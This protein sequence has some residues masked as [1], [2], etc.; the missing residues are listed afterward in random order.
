MSCVPKEDTNVME[1]RMLRKDLVEEAIQNLP[2]FFEVEQKYQI[3]LWQ[4]KEFKEK[5][6]K[7]DKETPN[8]R[9]ELLQRDFSARADFLERVYLASVDDDYID[10]DA[11]GRYGDFICSHN[12]TSFEDTLEGKPIHPRIKQLL[13]PL[14]TPELKDRTISGAVELQQSSDQKEM[15][16]EHLYPYSNLQE[17]L[18]SYEEV[19]SLMKKAAEK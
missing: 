17:M 7:L 11:F 6:K 16:D 12:Q 3:P 5:I 4:K 15:I 18:D 9:T 2:E 8:W 19:N 1:L 14:R 10:Q 13:N